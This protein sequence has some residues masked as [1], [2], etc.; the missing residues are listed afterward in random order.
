MLAIIKSLSWLFYFIVIAFWAIILYYI[1]LAV[2]GITYKVETLTEEQPMPVHFPSVDVLIPAHNEE[3][4]IFETLDSMASLEYPGKLEIY[5][6]NDNSQDRTGEYAD[7]WASIFK[8]IHHIKVPPGEP[9]GK[10]RVLNYGLTVS[11]G[12]VIAVYDADNHPEKNSV[13]LLVAKMLENIKYAG[14]IGY[15]KSYNM[16]KNILTTMIGLEIFLFQLLMQLGRWKLMKLGTFPGTNMVVKRKILED[17][18]GWDPYAL[19]EDADLTV[20]ITARGYL[21]PVQPRAVTWEQEPETFRV[22]FRQRTRWM[23]GNLYVARKVLKG[24][25]YF[26]GRN[27]WNSLQLISIYY[28]FFTFVILSDIWFVLGLLG[29]FS[30]GTNLPLMLLWFESWWIYTAQLVVASFLEG[31]L[32]LKN[33]VIAGIMYFTYAQAWLF[34]LFNAH[35]KSFVAWIRKRHIAWDKTPRFKRKVKS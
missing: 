23:L 27:L 26:K 21:L 3:E 5:L 8:N 14:A 15:Y 32:T 7:Y 35:W 16:H 6:L 31:E 19:A 34:I 13:K 4:V 2:A 12:E 28:V 20:D 24:G 22:W 9:K 30:T 10:A 33:V 25:K 29:I 1:V 17:V 11:D 18:G